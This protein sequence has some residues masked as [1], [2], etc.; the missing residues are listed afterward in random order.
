VR[1]LVTENLPL[2][3]LGG[4]SGILLAWGGLRLFVAAAPPGFPRLSELSLDLGVLAFT[5]VISVLAAVLF[6]IA[7]AVQAS[8]PDLAGSLKETTRSGTDGVTRQRLRSALGGGAD[9][10]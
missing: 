3:V 4:V 9:D 10:Q 6:G 8:N 7:P 5:L 1:Q 2:A